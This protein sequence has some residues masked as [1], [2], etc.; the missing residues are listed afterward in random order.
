MSEAYP[1][2]RMVC[3]DCGEVYMGGKK[4][5]FCRECIRKRLSSAAKKNNLNRIG[6][7]AHRRKIRE[8]K[9]NE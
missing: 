7:E 1:I 5:F 4:S 6:I 8:A 3:N 2:A 9:A